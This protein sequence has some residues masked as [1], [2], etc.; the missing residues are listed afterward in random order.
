MT[1]ELCSDCCR[2]L[3]Q[4]PTFGLMVTPPL[5]YALYCKDNRRRLWN[6]KFLVKIDKSM[7]VVTINCEF[8]L[9]RLTIFR[10]ATNA[11][12]ER[13]FSTLRRL[14]TWLRTTAQQVRLNWCT[15][16]H[17]HNN[18]TDNLPMC[19]VANEFVVRNDSRI[20]HFWASICMLITWKM[21]FLSCF[22]RSFSV[23]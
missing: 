17:V 6:L 13:T 15:I 2:W 14:K 22:Q 5:D 3:G 18:R 7:R 9:P 12:S 10:I 1:S 11:V 19:S 23:K 16:L 8:S 4:I 21:F 20:R